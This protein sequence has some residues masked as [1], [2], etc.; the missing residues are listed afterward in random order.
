[1]KKAIAI[2]VASVV[3]SLATM[4]TALA[5]YPPSPKP[6]TLVQGAGSGGAAETAF[7]GG[8]VTVA[9]IAVGI[10]AIVGLVA[11][12]VARSRSDRTV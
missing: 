10:L 4:T 1:M 9:A 11:L 12:Y 5:D 6:S 8:D 7:T 2:S 3:L